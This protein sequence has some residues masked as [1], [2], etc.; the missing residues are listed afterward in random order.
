MKQRF[1]IHQI[2][3]MALIILLV[4][5][6]MMGQRPPNFNPER[7][8]KRFI[9]RLLVRGQRWVK[10]SVRE[11]REPES[12]PLKEKEIRS[13]F[14]IIGTE[15][16]WL[17]YNE[18]YRKDYY[19]NLLTDL[20]VGEYDIDP[21]TGG[22]RNKKAFK[23]MVDR[24]AIL[25]SAYTVNDQL[26]LLVRLTYTGD[27][28]PPEGKETYL[29]DFLNTPDVHRVLC[30]SLT[31]GL[32]L[33]NETNLGEAIGVIVDFDEIPKEEEEGFYDFLRYLQQRLNGALYVNLPAKNPDQ[34]IFQADYVKKL[35]PIVNGFLLRGYGLE[36]KDTLSSGSAIVQAG[37]YDIQRAVD[38]YVNQCKID[39]KQLLVEFS[40]FGTVWEF[41][42]GKYHPRAPK[43]LVPFDQIRVPKTKIQLMEAEMSKVGQGKDGL[44]YTFDDEETLSSKYTWVKDQELGGVG[45]L[46]LGY[47]SNRGGEKPWKAISDGFS[48]DP[49]QTIYPAL[50]FLLMFVGFGIF[51]SVIQ[52]WQVR[53]EIARKRRHQWFYGLSLLMIVIVIL[54]CMIPLIPPEAKAG[55]STLMIMFPFLRRFRSMFRKWGLA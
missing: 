6:D 33:D 30:D 35:L 41:H 46:G 26:R 40:Y 36:R 14:R 1:L 27:F 34:S 53:N 13:Q 47:Y 32:R 9:N 42:H 11:L 24:R 50:A 2:L 22:Y 23:A 3:I 20:V 18:S 21:E 51:V 39:K 15:P 25:D 48:A 44:W 12:I 8:G 49:P 7:Q 10:R 55:S 43:P 31:K 28:G 16:S 19:F 52:H 29:V 38:Y 17:V 45:I 54:C 4:P 5:A 37:P